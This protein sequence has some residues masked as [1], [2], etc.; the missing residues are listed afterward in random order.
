MT[1]R[2]GAIVIGAGVIGLA[3]GRALARDGHEVI[4]LESNARI[5]EGVSA[6]NS[7][8]IHAGIYYPAGSLKAELC[9][10]GRNLLYDY[11]SAKGVDHARCGKLIVAVD[12]AQCT[13]LDAL[14]AKGQMNGVDDLELLTLEDAH[15]LAPA[16]RSA[17][18]LWSP[19][20]G[21]VDT[22]AL[23]LALQ[24]DLEAAGGHVALKTRFAHAIARDHVIDV[25]LECGGERSTYTA[26]ILVNCASLDA[27]HLARSIE[28]LDPAF[29]PL[30]ATQFA[31]G[32]YFMLQGK[33]PFS[34]LVYPLPEPGG[35][36]VHLTLDL[37]GR[38]RFGPD[39]EWI[40][41][42]TYDVDPGR[43]DAFYG[44]IRSYWP[45]LPDGSLV[46]GYAGIR[47]KIVGP[48]EPAADF[49]ISSP[50]EH[51]VAGLVN[52]FG[53]ESP[54]LTAALAIAE[55]VNASL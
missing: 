1:D 18:A 50:A 8:V 37:A 32:N 19:S 15:R 26:D 44:A 6:R 55:K 5:G 46:P 12:S 45:G 54:G 23:M 35:L 21:I 22:H 27:V 30:P 47:P 52:L 43:S 48:G 28:G 33:S 39:V 7:E 36:G 34:T 20:T 40:D 31:K 14:R 3:V 4:V 9:V 17:A 2:I 41:E 38:A 24:G 11:V 13:D 53:I 29:V 10:R 25:T 51:G 49:V 42:I 16:L